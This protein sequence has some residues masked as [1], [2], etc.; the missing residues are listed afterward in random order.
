MD[1]ALSPRTISGEDFIHSAK[2]PGELV[3]RWKRLALRQIGSPLPPA[4]SSSLGAG[5]TFWFLQ[6]FLYCA[7]IRSTIFVF[8]NY[9]YCF[10][11]VSLDS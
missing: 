11:R 6:G 9:L 5:V 1:S 2:K 4:S 3:R 10:D 8:L 7:V